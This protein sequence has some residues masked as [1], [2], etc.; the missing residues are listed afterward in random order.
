MKSTLL[1]LLLIMCLPSF[2]QRRNGQGY[3]M[4]SHVAIKHVPAT[5]DLLPYCRDV[6][7][8]YDENNKLVG[9]DDHVEEDM[10]VKYRKKKEH[11]V[12]GRTYYKGRL[13]PGDSIVLN[14]ASYSMVR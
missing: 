13:V 6:Y 1:T 7:Y 2:A 11:R 12:V 5:E 14:L 10:V 8:H 3:K 4:V 9:I